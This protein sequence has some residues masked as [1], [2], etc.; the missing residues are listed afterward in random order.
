MQ[1]RSVI[2]ALVLLPLAF[3]C[4][5]SEGGGGV[6]VAA[7]QSATV[8]C[9][10]T[11]LKVTVALASAHLGDEKCT[12]DESADVVA[13]SC[14]TRPADAGAPI[15]TGACGGPCD[16]SRLQLT[17][18]SEPQGRVTPIAVLSAAI[19]DAATGA[20]LQAISAYTPLAWDGVAYRPWDET[21]PPAAEVKAS[22]TLAP[23]SWSSIDPGYQM[24]RPYKVR[25][26]VRIDGRDL[27]LESTELH[28]EPVA[29]T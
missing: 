6:P 24:S 3:A 15:G 17:F 18:T 26:V 13:K 19:V 12:H 1:Q 29:A 16:F 14:A 11:G 10:T 8:L 25:L 28:R 21:V 22:Y 20:D 7:T 9:P 5:G 4:A 2:A 23:P 27:T